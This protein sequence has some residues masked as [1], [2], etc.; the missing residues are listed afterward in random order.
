[1]PI[2]NRH[3]INIILEA[4]GVE[5]IPALPYFRAT[6]SVLHTNRVALREVTQENQSSRVMKVP[7][8]VKIDEDEI[9]CAS[10][11]FP[12]KKPQAF[13]IR[14]HKSIK[15]GAGA[16]VGGNR[17]RLDLLLLEAEWSLMGSRAQYVAAWAACYLSAAALRNQPH[18]QYKSGVTPTR[19]MTH[20]PRAPPTP[21]PA[22]T[23][24]AMLQY[25]VRQ[26]CAAWRKMV[27]W[28]WFSKL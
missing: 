9:I 3:F 15:A 25:C 5:S 16:A 10:A 23:L 2:L 20:S 4:A 21:P 18:A 13:A 22:I 1:M 7:A 12:G 14:R 26:I 28:H 17:G 11:D 8:G 19:V 6:R 27:N 24:I